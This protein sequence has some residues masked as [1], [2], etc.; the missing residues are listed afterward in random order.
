MAY[1]FMV[2]LLL[3]AMPATA[4]SRAAIDTSWLP[5]T[6][7]E[8][9][10]A[11]PVVEKNAGVEALFWTIHVQDE[12]TGDGRE[13][14][15]VLNHY[16]RLKVFDQK[17]AEKAATLDIPF[18]EK[19]SILNLAARTIKPDGTA[20]ELAKD[21]VFERELVRA[22]GI[23][24]K[25]KSFAMPGVEPGVIVE[26]RWKEVRP[27][28]NLYMHLELQREFPAQRVTYYVKPLPHAYT[29]YMRGTLLQM[30]LRAF[31]IAPPPLELEPNNFN[32]LTVENIPAFH[33]EPM[34]PSEPN[35]RPW[36]LIYY[37]DGRTQ[38]PDKYWASE[39]KRI[40]D[41]W[42]EPLKIDDEIKRA[43][44]AA[45][46]GVSGEEDKAAALIRYIRKNLR[47]YSSRRV[48]AEE[49]Q[50]IAEE[51]RKGHRN[52]IEIFKSGI[53][54]SGELNLVFA[55][56]A[57]CAGLDAR[58]AFLADRT[59]LMFHKELTDTYF[60]H[61]SDMA[62]KIGDSWKLYE[63]SG[64]TL[65][66]SM[67]PWRDE[68]VMVLVGD[69]KTPRFVQSAI[70]P[71]E[72]SA[73]TRAAH[74]TLAEDG[75][76]EGDVE[77]SY[78][79]HA[80]ATLRGEMAGRSEGGQREVVRGTIRKMFATAEM[81]KIVIEGL[82]D[83]E[84][85]LKV[86]YHVKMPGYA[87]RTAKRI[88][89]Q[90]LLFQHGNA[91][92]FSATERRH[93]IEFHHA[94]KESDRIDIKFPAGFVLDSG[95][96]PRGLDFGKPGSYAVNMTL[97]PGSNVLVATRELTFGKDGNVI[98]PRESYPQLKLIFDEIHDRDNHVIAL[99][100]ASAENTGAGQ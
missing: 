32:S 57:S 39:G 43:A 7:A 54:N 24:V 46:E 42:K 93:D 63:V 56:M 75:T 64:S 73:T 58:P 70:S 28:V 72:A 85:P 87:Q 15:R 2:L 37:Y 90:P 91:S 41:E 76:L 67:I 74:M 1:R 89:L 53:G 35:V 84:K 10:L 45:T 23:R 20:L 22:S 79:G 33:S 27:G 60:L 80:A 99:K 59:S 52:S 71:P 97:P 61:K 9:S 4:Q 14:E 51:R 92:L 65:P 40:Y 17:G 69:P 34:M 29:P 6:D 47:E 18:E 77:E 25:V 82:D 26:Y 21:A 62:V 98:F 94:W 36:V 49:R 31:N 68:G 96:I 83:A 44:E 3:A 50:R 55:A 11:S 8:R 81:S 86:R 48:T 95:D 12:P 30:G 38:D 100:T 66:A 19:V 13:L 88:L 16:V 78:T 5:V